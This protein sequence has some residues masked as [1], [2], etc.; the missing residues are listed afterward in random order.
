MELRPNPRLQQFSGAA[1]ALAT[2]CL[3]LPN[4]NKE[5]FDA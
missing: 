5:Y 1:W 3:N 2:R 4:L